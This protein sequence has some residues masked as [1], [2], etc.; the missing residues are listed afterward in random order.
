MCLQFLIH[1][2]AQGYKVGGHAT[3]GCGN[4][5][6]L[7]TE[8]HAVDCMMAKSASKWRA[9]QSAGE[10]QPESRGLSRMILEPQRRNIVEMLVARS[11]R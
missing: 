5:L 6:T 10:M 8:T 9:V 2:R 11:Q 4:F 3:A 1:L 7:C